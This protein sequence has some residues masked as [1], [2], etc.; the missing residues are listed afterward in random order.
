MIASL[1][2]SG[3]LAAVASW[4]AATSTVV[5][6]QI[7][8]LRGQL[9]QTPVSPEATNA[10]A[11]SIAEWKQLQQS[12]SYS[13]DTY[14]RFL[15]AH[16]GWPNETALR[17]AA[18]RSLDIASWSPGVVASYF[19][20]FPPLTASGQLRFAEALSAIGQ[21][22]EANAAARAA[23]TQGTLPPSDETR[24]LARFASILTPQ[25][26]DARMDR[27]LWR[28]AT[29]S[30]QRQFSLVSPARRDLFAARLAFRSNSADAATRV[31]S[32]ADLYVADAGYI[33][34]R[35]MWLRNS[36]AQA[37]AW[38]WLAQRRGL[39][40]P[41]ADVE[42]WFDTL[43]TNA[44]AAAANGQFALTFDIARQIDDAYPPGTDISARP[45]GERDNY[46][47]LAWLAGQTAL[48]SL[49]RPADAIGMFERYAG[50]SQTPQTR[51]KGLY[52]AGRAAEAAG[53]RDRAL[54]LYDRAAQLRDQFYGQLA[55]ERLGR[56][57]TP[58]PDVVA[59][60]VDPAVR[61]AFYASE[62]VR[63]ARYLG[64]IGA[65]EDQTAFVRQI[66]NNAKSDSDHVLAIELSRTLGRP[67]LGV[68]VGRSA[69]KN[70]LTDYAATG[71]PSVRVPDGQADA[72]TMIHAI[73]RQE[74]QFDRAAISHAGARGL[75][76]LMPGTARQVAQNIGMS[77]DSAALTNN[78]DY[79]IQLGS[80]YFQ[81]MYAY[82]GSYPLAVAAYNA[83]PGNVNKWLAANGDPRAGQIDMVDWI[84]AIPI[85]ETRNYVQ[86]VL[87]NAVVYDLLNPQHS[88]S[89]GT[90]RLS[91][92]LGRKPG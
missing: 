14:S 63:A 40:S 33:N 2:R 4:L 36:G 11:A 6:D 49:G 76:Q 27:L 70:G 18:E 9:E 21:I 74:S 72:W 92:Y 85:Y 12:N 20:R 3:L 67:D 37:S 8:V 75:M 28:G 26:Q 69:L 62:V 47:S 80:T 19:R 86:R 81:K 83:G 5:Q 13:F 15:L 89:Q 73:A 90:A 54:A 39:A 31:A 24:L 34:D 79:N 35:A 22:D 45:Y 29:A 87:E 17:K 41:P 58:P 44:R 42:T 51:A 71:F 88:R 53:Q 43:L 50:G 77:Y 38:N 48:K 1:F 82:Y 52:W 60:P 57:I 68:M 91:W 10:L 78:T 46:T 7:G 66:A 25:D 30:A 59:R 55:N 16:P 61:D 32:V 65:H 23:W 64:T 56:A 84:E